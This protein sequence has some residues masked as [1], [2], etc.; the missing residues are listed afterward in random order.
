[1]ATTSPDGKL[2]ADTNRDGFRRLVK[3]LEDLNQT[4]NRIAKL[5]EEQNRKNKL[6]EID[7]VR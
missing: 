2:I 7:E 3:A 5:V 1:M 4:C 6:H